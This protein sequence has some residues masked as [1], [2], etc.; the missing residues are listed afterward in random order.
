MKTIHRGKARISDFATSRR[1]WQQRHFCDN[2]GWGLTIVA[3]SGAFL[4]RFHSPARIADIKPWFKISTSGKA[5]PVPD[6]ARW[7]P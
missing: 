7:S 5:G 3:V 6:A 1:T 2:A 4:C